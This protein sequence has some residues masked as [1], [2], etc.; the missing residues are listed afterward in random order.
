MEY[1]TTTTTS[2]RPGTRLVFDSLDL[3]NRTNIT[4]LPCPAGTYTNLSMCCFTSYASINPS[5]HRST[6][7][8]SASSASASL[9]SLLIDGDSRP[10]YLAATNCSGN[11][12]ATEQCPEGWCASQSECTSCAPGTY[13][14]TGSATSCLDC[15][16]GYV[17]PHVRGSTLATARHRFDAGVDSC[18][19]VVKNGTRRCAPCPAGEQSNLDKTSCV[20]CTPVRPTRRCPLALPATRCSDARTQQGTYNKDIGGTCQPCGPGLY[21]PEYNSSG[22]YLCPVGTYGD[23]STMAHCTDC[24]AGNYNNLLGL[25]SQSGCNKCPPGTYCPYPGTAALTRLLSHE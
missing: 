24:G 10:C 23:G 3:H 2:S 9:D 1:S 11:I 25:T 16:D 18:V 17:A 20:S 19:L 8:A 21:Q 6:S 13:Q 5:I 4:C 12:E 14:S 7:R 15:A 22:C